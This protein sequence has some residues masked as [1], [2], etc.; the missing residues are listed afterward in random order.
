MRAVFAGVLIGLVVG[1]AALAPPSRAQPAPDFTRAKELYLAAEQAMTDGRFTDAIRDYGATFEITHDP[2]LFYKIGSAHEKAGTCD[3][4]L[5]YYG[6]YIKEAR[7][8]DRY[9]E[10]TKARVRACGGDDRSTVVNRLPDPGPGSAAGSATPA[11]AGAG[12]ADGS[13]AGS[14]D[15][16]P[17]SAD[18][19]PGSAVVAGTGAGS[20]KGVTMSGRHRGAWLLVTTSIAFVTVGS[21]LA[22]SANSAESDITDLYQGFTGT[23]ASFDAKT[24]ATYDDLVAEGRRYEKLSW[25]SFGLAGVT[26]AGAVILFKT[27]GDERAVKV[28]PTVSTDGAGVRATLRW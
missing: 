18:P 9:V 17:A 10:L 22:Y 13:G 4:A 25:A 23:P 3:V 20:A 14:A 1:G 15:P 21:V 7:P 19:G 28:T 6:R 12:S 26:A 24:R 27:G 11:D 16:G 2:V 8:T 5:I